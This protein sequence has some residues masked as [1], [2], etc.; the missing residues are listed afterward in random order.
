MLY[1]IGAGLWDEKDLSLRALNI[2]KECDEIFLESYT[3]IWKGD[4]KN[5]G[6]EAKEI[7]RSEMEEG[8]ERILEKAKEKKVAILVPGDP[9]TATTHL[10]VLE[11]AKKE[12]IPVKI[13][14]NTSIKIAI[15]ET[16]LQLYKFG[17]TASI[18]WEYSEY[19]YDILKQNR[20][21][22]AH[23]L[24][25]LDLGEKSM[26]PK[27]G[28]NRLL[29]IEKKRK[30]NLLNKSTFCMVACRLGAED[31]KIYLGKIKELAHIEEIPAAIILPGKLHFSEKEFLN[32]FKI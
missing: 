12:G 17:K 32:T 3:S 1:L 22:D 31:K 25:L 9:L 14:H 8:A 10:S 15:A 24:F 20:S 27:Q 18:S 19:P 21:I 4:L 6:L 30:E 2:L 26:T 29:E 23:T 11:E 5:L 7:G 13:I 16:G 28:L